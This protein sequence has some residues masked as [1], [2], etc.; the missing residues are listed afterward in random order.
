MNNQSKVHKLLCIVVCFFCIGIVNAFA[1]EQKV[2]VELKNATLRQVFKSIE[3]QTTYR[4]SY[5]NALVDDKNDITISQR[6]VGV[7][8]VLNEALEGRNLTY[9]IVSAKSIVISDKEE[10]TSPSKNKRISGT[11]KMSTGESIIGANVK[12][13]GAT[14]GCITDL[15]GNFALEVPTD[16]K[17]T[18]SYIGCQTQEVST[19]G[20]SSLNIVLKEDTE[21]LDEVV[22]VGYGTQKKVNLTGA[23]ASVQFDDQIVSRSLTNSSSALAGMI[24][25]LTVVQSSSQPG[26][27]GADLKV[28]GIGT[29]NDANPLIVVD[30]VP[31][32]DINRL[33]MND[34][35]SISVLKDAASAAI[36]GS[37]AANGV[38]LV[39][40]KRG[41]TGEL[42]FSYNGSYAIA[43]PIRKQH[44][45]T[46]YAHNMDLLDRATQFGGG[47]RRYT[48]GTIDEWLAGALVNPIL[49]PSTDWYDILFQNG[50]IQNHNI[51]ING[52]SDK[53]KFYGSIGMMNNNGVTPRTYYRRYNVRLN[54]DAQF[55]KKLSAGI[56][57]DGQWTDQD[58]PREFGISDN[59]TGGGV[60][61]TTIPGILAVHPVTG[62]YGGV[63]AAGENASVS[64]I[65]AYLNDGNNPRRWQQFN[66]KIFAE[67]KLLDGLKLKADVALSTNH[68]FRRSWNTGWKGTNFATGEVNGWEPLLSIQN[69]Y[70]TWYKT[71]SVFTLNYEK[72]IG[73]HSLALLAGYNEEYWSDNWFM[74]NSSA[75]NDIDLV[76][77]DATSKEVMSVGGSRSAEALRSIFGRLNYNYKD[78]YLLEFNIRSD[79]SSKFSP[80]HRIGVFPSFSAGWR[81]SEENF[82]K[83][84]LKYVNN[85]KL[86]LS[87]GML[88]NNSGVGRYQ[89]AKVYGSVAYPFGNNKVVGVYP[90]KYINEDL[91]WETTIVTDIGVDVTFLNKFSVVVD[92]YHKKT[93]DMIR[94]MDMSTIMYGYEGPK[95]NLG[96]LLNQG[97]EMTLRYSDRVMDFSWN[98]DVNL[99]YNRSRLLKWNETLY[100]GAL[101][102]GSPYNSIYSYKFDKIAQTYDDVYNAPWHGTAN[103]RPGD[104]IYKDLN[105]DGQIDGSD[106][107][108]MKG[109]TRGAVTS[110]GINLGGKWKSIDVS[111]FFQGDFGRKSFWQESYN[112]TDVAEYGLALST[113]QANQFWT[114]ENRGAKYPRLSS[115]NFA[116][117]Q[118][119]SDFWLYSQDYLRLK[120]MQI[121]YTLPKKICGNIGIKH[122]RIFLSGENLFT[123]T[124]WPGIDPEKGTGRDIYPQIRTY[125]L[126]FNINI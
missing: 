104:I 24:P 27:D 35:E 31:D 117:N 94:P 32:M 33:N 125:S 86:R 72:K 69:Q 39:T 102:I 52:G 44:N 87:Y 4:F 65:L 26:R 79:E 51:S 2:T 83:P 120:N 56:M 20:K 54:V 22:V 106:R 121:G 80:G 11:V 57:V 78:R 17:L 90:K 73:N 111:L 76:E 122:L 68:D 105:G 25:G 103:L 13:V 108:L 126:G 50:S 95:A 113:L 67:Y 59:S 101:F 45:I 110:L 119:A 71:T 70:N 85:V 58:S 6:Q 91:S 116:K 5:R 21:M 112:K 43:K 48:Q 74:A 41:S 28:R 100:K 55:T 66:G 42:N 9:S 92:Y 123:L 84:L 97:M 49:Y 23:V 98:A 3:G 8:V 46:S 18:V 60:Y 124:K 10:K 34:I 15:D 1:Q 96:E 47:Q 16:A 89:Q 82:M 14:I 115:A 53:I 12:V 107:E 63:Q 62:E 93:V 37:R 81:V 36:Y 7:S 30:G 114:L 40:T 88:G 99:S 19:A 118:Y 109:V 38:I 77:I 61:D 75:R 64:N 29:V